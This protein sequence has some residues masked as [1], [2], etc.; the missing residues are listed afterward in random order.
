MRRVPVYHFTFHAFGT[1]PADHRRGYTE[2]G[3]GYQ[4]PDPE[5][6]R[7]REENLTQPLVSFDESM[8][9]VLIVGTYDICQRRGWR[10]HGAGNDETHFHAALSWKEFIEWQ[11]VRDK[12]KN[13]LSLFL[14]RLTGINGRTWFV[15]GASRKR[16]TTPEHLNYLLDTYFPDHRGVFWREGMVLPEIPAWVLMGRHRPEDPGA[17]ASG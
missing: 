13:L 5:E 14:G 4:P 7:R 12:L 10:F 6:Q 1:W 11:E 8:Q 16:V 2:R 9:K 3:E 15:E 17:S